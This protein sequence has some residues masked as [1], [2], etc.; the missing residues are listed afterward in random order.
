[1]SYSVWMPSVFKNVQLLEL[2]DS[3]ICV[4]LNSA[5]RSLERSCSIS[6]T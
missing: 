3:V 6:P 1:M 4:L 5:N 2:M